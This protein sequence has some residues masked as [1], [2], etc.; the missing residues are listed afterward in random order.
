MADFERLI[1]A[2]VTVSSS[3]TRQSLARFSQRLRHRGW[4]VAAAGKEN[5]PPPPPAVDKRVKFDKRVYH[6][7]VRCRPAGDVRGIL[8]TSSG[9][10]PGQQPA[11]RMRAYDEPVTS[12]YIGA[13]EHLRMPSS[14]TAVKRSGAAETAKKTAKR[15]FGAETGSFDGNVGRWRTKRAFFARFRRFFRGR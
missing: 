1:P 13:G 9:T 8:K 10:R 12:F 4:T 2:P 14:P 3:F 6:G 11:N 5:V 7:P 15:R